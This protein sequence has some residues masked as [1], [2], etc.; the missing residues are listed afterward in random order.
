MPRRNV[1]GKVCVRMDKGAKFYK[2]DFQV[3]SPRDINWTGAAAVTPEERATYAAEF[4]AACRSCGLDSVAITDHHD[5]VFFSYIKAAAESETDETGKLLDEH[6]RIV[7][8]PGME[9]TLATPPC[10]A[11]LIL[12]ADFPAANLQVLTV[13]LAIHPNDSAA[14]HHQ[15]I[16]AL[17]SITD[18]AHLYETLNAQQSLRGRFIVFPHVQDG[19]HKTLLRSGF[20][21]QYASMPCVGGYVD[22]SVDKLGNGNVKIL[23]GENREYGFKALG[24]FQTSDNRSR[25]FDKLGKHYS[26]VK[27]SEPTAEALRQGCLARQTR[28]THVQPAIPSARIAAVHVSNSKFLGPIDL[29]LNPQYNAL[30]GGRGT[31]KSTILE[32]LRWGLCDQ[33]GL[34][35]ELGIS[36]VQKKRRE[37]VD[38]TLKQFEATVTIHIVKNQTLHI[39]KRSAATGS[40]QLKIGDAQF[41]VCSELDVQTLV[42]IQAYSQK[43]LSGVGVRTD[44]LSRF[45]S[46]SIQQDLQ[47]IRSSVDDTRSKL[48]Q[49]FEDYSRLVRARE[50]KV[51]LELELR[52]LVDQA[53]K[54]RGGAAGV[55]P[56]HKKALDDYEAVRSEHEIIKSWERSQSQT[57]AAIKN[58][59]ELFKEFPLASL[60]IKTTFPNHDLL[61][62]MRDALSSYYIEAREQLERLSDKFEFD[63]KKNLIL[64]GVKDFFVEWEASLKQHELRYTD[65]RAQNTSH[66][67]VL[68]SLKGIEDRSAKVR[69]LIRDKDQEIKNLADAERL[70][71]ECRD[72]LG[73]LFSNR[74]LLLT[75]ECE[76]LSAL[77]KGFIKAQLQAGTGTAA[78]EEILRGVLKG[79]NIRGDKQAAIFSSVR[80]NA[81]P[82]GVWQAILTELEQLVVAGTV[83]STTGTLPSTPL[84]NA[85]NFADTDRRKVQEKMTS[86]SWLQLLLTE[87]DDVPYFEYR[88]AEGQYIPFADA[89]AGQ[90]ATALMY[91]LLNMEGPPL[92]VDQPE[93]D[94]DN[95]VIKDIVTEIWAAKTKRQLVFTSHNANI[96][97]N[98]DAEL[99]VCCD[100]RVSGDQTG[101][102]IVCEGAIDVLDIRNRIT[103]VMEGGKQ[104]FNL[105]REKYGF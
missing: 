45:L 33:T 7:V 51:R 35:D 58:A 103:S 75:R 67:E 20:H 16:Q 105:R 80:E 26:W 77:S 31:G 99:V 97:V 14:E 64:T 53:K 13:A 73:L 100:Y 11:L 98:G 76:K 61:I 92:V 82:R 34:A 25:A 68:K 21:H 24:V 40:I 78:A 57:G 93:D 87:L 104:A 101:G 96:V 5:T 42:P 89:S 102:K 70:F 43:Q 44:E 15:T 50:E 94:L 28:I 3:H 90:Q 6:L 84:L 10:Q 8:F 32:Y 71:Q 22:G 95:N 91:V 52:S 12:D 62:K 17:T 49:S 36:D 4:I 46:M 29:E 39:V 2:C 85:L 54:L 63:D 66:E 65:A 37:L 88:S 48:R 81:D 55:S 1:F 47:E 23:N 41:Q 27:W 19:G 74:S 9:L 69:D 60:E 79:S 18:L 83:D 30:I 38:K 86:E 72:R 56:V 59:A